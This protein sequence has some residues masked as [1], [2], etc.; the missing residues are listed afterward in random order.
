MR[1]QR[2]AHKVPP[3]SFFFILRSPAR[4]PSFPH[5][6]LHLWLCT[7]SPRHVH[8][9]RDL[10]GLLLILLCVLLSMPSRSHRVRQPLHAHTSGQRLLNACE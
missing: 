5:T 7:S 8:S 1:M 10:A 6:N 2:Y 4:F 3:Q 9:R